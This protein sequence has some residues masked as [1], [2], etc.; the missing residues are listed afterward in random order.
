MPRTKR[1]INND[2]VQ[3]DLSAG[4]QEANLRIHCDWLGKNFN[5]A[6]HPDDLKYILGDID[7]RECLLLN[8]ISL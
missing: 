7:D 2:A 4:R 6:K 8:R 3:F 1:F 5:R